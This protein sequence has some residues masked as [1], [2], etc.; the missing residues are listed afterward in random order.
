MAVSRQ[1]SSDFFISFYLHP[2]T[3]TVPV[4][5]EISLESIVAAADFYTNLSRSLPSTGL[6]YLMQ[7]TMLFFL[8]A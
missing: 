6:S 8:M 7:R 1:F 2:H 3:T 5:L 4:R